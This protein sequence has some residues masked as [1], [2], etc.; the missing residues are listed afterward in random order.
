MKKKLFMII[1]TFTVLLLMFTNIKIVFSGKSS[2]TI[3]L[4]TLNLA[5][6]DDEG[7]PSTPKCLE[8]GFS[9]PSSKAVYDAE[10][11]SESGQVEYFTSCEESGPGCQ[12]VKWV[13]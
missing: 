6:A 9:W 3:S 7:N 13:P 8:L 12:E 4:S 5:M 10:F 11:C 2:S 1:C